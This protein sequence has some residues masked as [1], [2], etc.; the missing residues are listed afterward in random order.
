MTQ[1]A[2]GDLSVGEALDLGCELAITGEHDKA[3]GWFRGVLKHEPTNFEAT[4]RLGVSL[5]ETGKLHE[6]L[7]WFWRALK[8]SRRHPLALM[9]YGLCLGQLGH[10]DEGLPFLER[11]AKFIEKDLGFTIAAKAMVYNNLGNTLERL[12]RYAEALAALD[13]GIAYAPDDAFPHYNRGIALIRLNRHRDGIAA[14]DR[15]LSLRPASSDSPS[16]LN[17]ADARYNRAMAR[18]YLGDLKGFEDYEY[19]LL[20]SENK[21]PNFGLNAA[22]KWTG[23]EPI[24][25]KRLLV[26]CEQGLGDTIQFLRFLPPL[27]A[28]GANVKVICH[29]ESRVLIEQ[30]EGVE[31]P[32]VGTPFEFDLWVPLMSLPLCAGVASEADIPPPW[33]PIGDGDSNMRWRPQ[34]RRPGLVNVGICWAGNW[35]HKNDR[36]RSIPL[37]TFAKLF[38]APGCN[39][40][41]LQQMRAEDTEPFLDLTR[42]RSNLQALWLDDWRDTAA[43]I[44][45]L[46]LV[47]TADTAIAHLAASIGVPTWV[48]IPAFATDWR[49]QIERTDSPWYP[50]AKLYRQKKIGDWASVISRVRADLSATAAK[51]GI[52]A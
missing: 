35:L 52:G 49:W 27:I 51:A 24:E 9:N 20:T 31:I 7:Y 41:S 3:M 18:L 28:R 43:V 8:L 33:A 1:K 12:D 6:A 19:R 11:A 34:V 2:R 40:V 36:H 37:A 29:R 13:K 17:E 39:F 22:K 44:R 10:A 14:L 48:L 38:E 47:I 32:E 4:L 16:R 26:R 21:L 25:G 50:A 42:A 15:S 45:N 46:D 30:I 5:F 23:A